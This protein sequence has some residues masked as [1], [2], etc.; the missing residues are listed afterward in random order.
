MSGA[1]DDRRAASKARTKIGVY[2]WKTF[3]SDV[4][5]AAMLV[6]LGYDIGDGSRPAIERAK[7]QFE[8]ELIEDHKRAVAGDMSPHSSFRCAILADNLHR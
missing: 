2:C 7:Q 5:L 6:D 4:D 3:H 1:G 8:S